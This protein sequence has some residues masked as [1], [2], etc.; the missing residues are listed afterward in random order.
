[1]K[2]FLIFQILLSALI[3]IIAPGCTKKVEK[4]PSTEPVPH[5]VTIPA[6]A[7][8]AVATIGGEEAWGNTQVIIGEC[9]A[10]FYKPDGTFYLTRQ[11]HAVYPWSDSIRI[12]AP[13]PQG[14]FV[15]QLTGGNFTLLEGSSW[16]VA[17]LPI[18]ICDASIARALWNIIA[19][20]AGIATQADPNTATPGKVIRIEGLWHYPLALSD[21]QTFYLNKDNNIFDIYLLRDTPNTAIMAR[22]YD[23]RVIA[24]TNISVP[25]KV[26][27]FAADGS[28]TPNRK[29]AEFDYHTYESV[30][31]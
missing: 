26:E 6:F 22:G 9:S 1:M 15:W 12:Y 5:V 19:A 11:R 23:Y 30:V 28:C 14:T 29:I 7:K 10:K 8:A 16:Q 31:F 13:E 3:L 21:T 25:S 18:T 20:P 17:A 2:R 4:A 27:L 24:K